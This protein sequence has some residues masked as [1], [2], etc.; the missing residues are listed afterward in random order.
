MLAEFEYRVDPAY[1]A[2]IRER[3]AH[4]DTV[5]ET[6]GLRDHGKLSRLLAAYKTEL[7]RL[8]SGQ[9]DKVQDARA[10]LV[11]LLLVVDVREM[12][13]C[14]P[15]VRDYLPNRTPKNGAE[16]IARMVYDAWQQFHSSLATL[17]R[18]L[19]AAESYGR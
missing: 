18:N 11:G 16:E 14:S 17:E 19:K 15:A 10:I 4:I 6:N 3:I 1:R 8:I 5:I 2:A 9:P 7:N 12:L 13:Q